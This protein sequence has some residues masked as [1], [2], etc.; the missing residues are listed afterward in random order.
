[1]SVEKIAKPF[2]APLEK[3]GTACNKALSFEEEKLIHEILFEQL[4]RSF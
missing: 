3:I 4:Q 2:R 1:M